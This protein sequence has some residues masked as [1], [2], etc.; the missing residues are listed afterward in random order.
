[1]NTK[2][3]IKKASISTSIA[4]SLKNRFL[5]KSAE[6]PNYSGSDLDPNPSILKNLRNTA[7]HNDFFFEDGNY[8]NAGIYGAGA[9]GIIGALVNAAR[10]KNILTGALIGAGT[11]GALGAGGKYLSDNYLKPELL[12]GW[13]ADVKNDSK[14]VHPAWGEPEFKENGRDYW[15]PNKP[16]PPVITKSPVTTPTSTITSTTASTSKNIVPSNAT[17]T[18]NVI[19][20]SAPTGDAIFWQKHDEGIKKEEVEHSAANRK[21]H[22]DAIN[23]MNL[24]KQQAIEEENYRREQENAELEHRALI[25]L[26]E[27]EKIKKQQKNSRDVRNLARLG[28]RAI[29]P[30]LQYMGQGWDWINN[31][32]EQMGRDLTFDQEHNEG[33]KEEQRS[34]AQKQQK[35][36]EDATKELEDFKR[37]EIYSTPPT[38]STNEDGYG[39]YTAR[40]GVATPLND[41]EKRLIQLYER[42]TADPNGNLRPE[43]ETTYNMLK[44]REKFTQEGLNRQTRAMSKDLKIPTLYTDSDGIEYVAEQ[45]NLGKKLI[46]EDFMKELDFLAGQYATIEQDRKLKESNPFRDPLKI[47]LS[48][49]MYN[50]E[51]LSRYKE[52]KDKYKRETGHNYINPYTDIPYQKLKDLD[53]LAKKFTT[54]NMSSEDYRQYMNL[55][56]IWKNTF[57]FDY[58]NPYTIK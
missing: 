22:R 17:E 14:I 2:I 48:V 45:N 32:L 20:V 12:K 42:I 3:L 26:E 36:Y 27:Q 18:I 4:L 40:L 49:D 23:D 7:L 47:D 38:F 9:G 41:N 13:Q 8:L 44:E 10:G 19:P 5:I 34:I 30:S 46:G 33:I 6:E 11:G 25:A 28:K 53:Q 56:N 43:D 16:Q 54:N 57:G 39:R 31:N 35:A 58:V 21:A 50:T 15:Y 37:K 51:M 1:M 55:C 29:T 24:Y 52:F